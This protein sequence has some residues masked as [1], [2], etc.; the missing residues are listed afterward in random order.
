MKNYRTIL[1]ALAIGWVLLI[2]IL[3]VIELLTGAF[4][5]WWE[6]V[7]QY[8]VMVLTIAFLVICGFYLTEKAVRQTVDEYRK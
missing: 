3:A 7:N 5:S 4:T 8:K 1:A 2:S 6:S